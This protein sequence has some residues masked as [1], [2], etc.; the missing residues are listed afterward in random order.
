MEMP[1]IIF[2]DIISTDVGVVINKLPPIIK[3][4]KNM[5]KFELNERDGFLTM[6]Y[7][8][9]KGYVKP[10]ECTMTDKANINQLTSWLNGSGKVIFS[11]EPEMIYDATIINKIP[12]ES[13]VDKFRSFIIQFECQPFKRQVVGNEKTYDITE[14]SGGIKFEGKGNYKSKPVIT[15]YGNGSVTLMIN[16][17]RVIL[18]NVVDEITVNSQIMDCYKQGRLMNHYMIGEFP[19]LNPTTNY[20][21]W[22]GNISQIKIEYN[23]RWL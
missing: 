6:D 23:W 18:T 22:E 16:E 19:T 14:H 15:V 7:G 5:E 10:V 11:N 2:N 3:P 4:E 9:Y 8:T 21:G 1:Y 20:L 13:I 17:Q 12:F